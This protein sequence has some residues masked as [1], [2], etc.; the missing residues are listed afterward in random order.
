MDSILK[1]DGFQHIC[2]LILTYLDYKSLIACQK[3]SKCFK[4]ILDRPV[5]WINRLENANLDCSIKEWRLVLQYISDLKSNSHPTKKKVENPRFLEMS[6]TKCLKRFFKSQQEKPEAKYFKKLKYSH[7]AARYGNSAMWQLLNQINCTNQHK[8]L[9]GLGLLPI[10]EAAHI[11]NLAVVKMHKGNFLEEDYQ[12]RTPIHLAVGSGSLKTVKF[13]CKKL[14]DSNLLASYGYPPIDLSVHYN[15][16]LILKYL[17]SQ[18]QEP[19]RPNQLG[20]SPLHRAA[21]EGNI[22]M[23]KHLLQFANSPNILTDHGDSL[24]LMAAAGGEKA[25]KLIKF[26]MPSMENPMVTNLDGLSPIHV[27]S[28]SGNHSVVKYLCQQFPNKI[29]EVVPGNGRT[30]ISYA[31]GYGHVEVIKVIASKLSDPQDVLQPDLN[32]LNPIH[33]AASNGMAKPLRYLAK[34]TG[35]PNAPVNG[36]PTETPLQMAI[37]NNHMEAVKVMLSVI[38]EKLLRADGDDKIALLTSISK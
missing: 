12:G 20:I 36:Q 5:F 27:A 23:V 2:E 10:H 4:R 1:H 38:G 25:T 18:T 26:L 34:F 15:M 35:N 7:I 32:G 6:L 16:F 24:I 31:A 3:V 8:E 19:L 21:F 17:T 11:G 22:K 37:R 28:K 9:S 33:H 29:K 30:A 14:V 13:L